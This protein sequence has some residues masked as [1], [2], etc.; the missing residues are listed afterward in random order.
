MKATLEFDLNDPDDNMAHLRCTMALNMALLLW[1]M[2]INLS[3]RIDEDS[4]SG[5]V[6][7]GIDIVITEIN[8]M[9]DE[10]GINPENLV[11]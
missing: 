3:R 2:K 4:F 10:Y 9:Y 5:D 1:E 6:Q 7:R 8:K 11:Q